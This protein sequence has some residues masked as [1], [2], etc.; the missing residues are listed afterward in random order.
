MDIEKTEQQLATEDDGIDVEIM[1]ATGEP[2]FIGDTDVP[3]TIK[4]AGT[5]SKR[6]RRAEE[7][8]RK[9]ILAKRGKQM[10]GA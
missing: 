10:S 2:E 3:L 7:W 5:Y 1:G 4:V 8:Q 9:Q 6:H